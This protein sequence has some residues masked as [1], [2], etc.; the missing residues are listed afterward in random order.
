MIPPKVNETSKMFFL[1]KKNA[2][3]VKETK[4]TKEK[5]EQA[6]LRKKLRRIY[7]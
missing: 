4:E 3:E 2:K 6:L 1:R 5:K 7:K